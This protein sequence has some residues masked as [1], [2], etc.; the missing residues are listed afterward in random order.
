MKNRREFMK[1]PIDL[2]QHEMGLNSLDKAPFR[3]FAPPSPCGGQEQS[4]APQLPLPPFMGERERG[5]GGSY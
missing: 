5:E 2:I 1:M 3:R 4:V